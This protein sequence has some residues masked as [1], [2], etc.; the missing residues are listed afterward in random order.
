MKAVISYYV[1]I[2][3]LGTVGNIL[4]IIGFVR[5]RNRPGFSPVSCFFIICLASADLI[6]CSV[7]IQ[8]KFLAHSSDFVL[9]ALNN[10]IVLCRVEPLLKASVVPFSVLMMA[11]VAVDRYLFLCR[12]VNNFMNKKIAFITIAMIGF[13]SLSFGI[14]A[15]FLVTLVP[16]STLQGQP[17]VTICGVDSNR[18]L[19]GTIFSYV[20]LT[21]VWG[22][23]VSATTLYG[24]V[25]ASVLR[26]RRVVWRRK[27]GLSPIRGSPSRLTLSSINTL[28]VSSTQGVISS[29]L[30]SQTLS[31]GLTLP[32]N[33][34]ICN[35][36]PSGDKLNNTS[37]TAGQSNNLLV[38]GPELNRMRIIKQTDNNSGTNENTGKVSQQQ[39]NSNWQARY[40]LRLNLKAAVMLFTVTLVFV[41]FFTP[42]TLIILG[43]LPDFP[44]SQ[45]ELKQILFELHFA[46]AATNP[47]IYIF[48]N[49][50]IRREMTMLL[51]HRCFR[52]KSPSH[53][54]KNRP[55]LNQS[56][57]NFGETA[58]I[59]SDKACSSPLM[60]EEEHT[61]GGNRK[62][63]KSFSLDNNDQQS[64][65]KYDAFFLR[66]HFSESEANGYRAQS[67][68]KLRSFKKQKTTF[69]ETLPTVMITNAENET[70]C[71]INEDTA[72]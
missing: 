53:V 21:V 69:A 41:I 4:A 56:V 52:V 48:L 46:S 62:K 34:S 60:A 25:Y 63:K 7:V 58:A 2:S 70:I 47:F 50:T 36:G 40:L 39:R 16:L 22:S 57:K 26:R 10:S 66:K 1:I 20:Q 49:S 54:T 65:S 32:V 14:V 6:L 68:K 23:V 51:C 37:S 45:L 59:K 15:T 67:I 43:W 24:I 38:P 12:P 55:S 17:E 42:A 8:L 72:F 28:M 64:T 19:L 9:N 13:I 31:S 33:G 29:S 61:E 35:E 30:T 18:K 3:I 71:M 5:I 11:A 44:N 27:L